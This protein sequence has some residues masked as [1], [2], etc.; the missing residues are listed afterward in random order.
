MLSISKLIEVIFSFALVVNAMLFIPQAVKIFKLKTARGVSLI[1]FLGFLIIQFAT[2]CHGVIQGDMI[3]IVGYAISMLTTAAVVALILFYKKKDKA[4]G[5]EIALEEILEQFPGHIYWKDLDFICRGSNKNNWKDFGCTSLEDL[6]GK[7]DYDILPKE[8][9]DLVRKNDLEVVNTGNYLTIEEPLINSNGENIIYLSHK[10]P[11]KNRDGEIIGILGVSVDVT[12]SKQKILEELHMLNNII[13]VMPGN[14]YWMD[15]NGVYLGC[16]NNQAKLIGLS[17]RQAIIGKKNIDIPGFLIPDA[18]DP[19]DQ[20]IMR[21]GVPVSLE[22]P[23]V[24]PDGTEATFMSN[25]VPLKNSLGEVV[26]LLGISVDI[27]ERKKQESELKL[28]KEAAEAANRAKTEFVQNMQHDIRTPSSGIWGLLDSLSKSEKNPER[29]KILKMA[30]ESSKRLLDLCNDAV[31]FGDLE[32]HAKPVLE[33][34]TDPREI[35]RSVVELNLPAIF[36]KNL[37]LNFKVD[38]NVPH[39]IK[40]DPFRLS[41]ILINLLGNAVKFTSKGSISLSL[42]ATK[43]DARR[44]GMLVIVLRDTGI[45][46]SKDK[47]QTVF[48]KFSRAVASNTNKYPGSGLGL[49]V[50]KTFLDELDGDIELES[51]EGKGSCFTVT[52]PFKNFLLTEGEPGESID[53]QYHSPLKNESSKASQSS[54]IDKIDYEEKQIKPLLNHKILIIEDDKVCLFAEKQIISAFT[55]NIDTAKNMREALELLARKQ[56]DL[57]ISDLGLPDG[58][59]AEIAALIRKD[60]TSPNQKT[61]FIAMTAHRDKEKHQEALEAGFT[62]IATKPLTEERV[63]HFLN[64]YPL[65]EEKESGDDLEVIDLESTIQRLHARNVKGALVGL[66]ILS[67]SLKEDILLLQQ[68]QKQNDISGAREVLHKIRSGLYYSGTPRLEKAV[69]DL[70]VAVKSVED[71]KEI[72]DKFS[73]VYEEV[74]QFEEYYKAILAEKSKLS[75]E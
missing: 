14:V 7:T 45:G 55:S 47:I 27:T 4:I 16:N 35:A 60:D 39:Y 75:E 70:H 13:A 21:K 24:L 68:T 31:E 41:R 3:L 71:L 5:K 26:G 59:G 2:I 61:T 19:V 57:V 12:L 17:S 22:E 52:I 51:H 34:K 30:T 44:K 40:S 6:V 25:K 62:E 23:A 32:G 53:E 56:Y 37:S 54:V 69:V 29:Q 72:A 48:Q 63:Q 10:Q 67:N 36:A 42:T 43:E 9:A 50:I 73:L 46:I 28:A 74:N 20:D 18:L 1:T 65:G 15:K 66:G 38:V 64:I 8:Q 33:K 11:L 58:S 49:Y